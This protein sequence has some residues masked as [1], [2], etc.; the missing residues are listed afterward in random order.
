MFM[1]KILGHFHK[2]LIYQT[3]KIKAYFLVS[4]I[5]AMY[6]YNI[7]GYN[8]LKTKLSKAQCFVK[9]WACTGQT[10]AGSVEHSWVIQSLTRNIKRY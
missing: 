4:S 9:S 8:L 7:S 2:Y 10:S 6:K 5:I 1:F 3:S